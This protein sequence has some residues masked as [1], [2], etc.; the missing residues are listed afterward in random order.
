MSERAGKRVERVEGQ[1]GQAVVVR[2]DDVDTDR[3]IPARYMTSITFAG[4]ED[5]VF[6][7][8][9]FTPDGTEK[10]HPFNEKR[11][12]NASILVVN[13][14]FGCGSSREHAP[15]A[16]MRWGIRAIVGESF[17]EI[18]FGNCVALGI[19]AVTA[20]EDDVAALMD[21]VEL[22]PSQQVRVDLAAGTVSSRAGTVRIHM[23][24]GPRRQLLE[25]TWDSVRNLLDA[26]DQIAE[27]ARRLPY[28]KG[29]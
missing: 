23:P 16:L 6:I 14:N 2:G 5:Y 15:Q 17:A 12:Q 21:A 4:L 9:R 13:K 28:I 24:E 29:F 19:L 22:D 1:V 18:F 26:G 27:T 25:G 3:I 8:A 20:S 10:D 11:F 7:D